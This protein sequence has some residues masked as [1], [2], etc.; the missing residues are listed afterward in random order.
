MCEAERLAS[1]S[2]GCDIVVRPR[3]SGAVHNVLVPASSDHNFGSVFRTSVVSPQ[4]IPNACIPFGSSHSAVPLGHARAY[5][6]PHYCPSFK[7]A[8][9]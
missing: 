6:L 3:D 4:A 5:S 9:L 1:F 2:V 8:D 7:W